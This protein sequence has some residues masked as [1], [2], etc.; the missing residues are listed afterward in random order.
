[1]KAENKNLLNPNL[2]R[3]VLYAAC[4]ADV[5]RLHGSRLASHNVC[6]GDILPGVVVNF[7]RAE[8]GIAN[9]RVEHDGWLE[10]SLTVFSA[11]YTRP[12]INKQGRLELPAGAFCWANDPWDVVKGSGE[13]DE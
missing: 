8:D 9:L 13:Y 12:K 3:P 5:L 4:A 1:M 10:G 11:P 6:A 7:G 2:G